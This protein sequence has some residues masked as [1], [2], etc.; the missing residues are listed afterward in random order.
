MEKKVKAFFYEYKYYRYPEGCNCAEDI[1]NLGEFKAARLK[2]ELCM[3]PDFV[4]ESIAEESVK[5]SDGSH[6]FDVEVNLYSCEEYDAL[7]AEQV[8]AHCYGCKNFGGDPSDLEGHHSEI[9]LDGS[10][11]LRQSK[12]GAWSYARCI[13]Y[14]WYRISLRLDAL[15][16]LIDGKRLGALNRLINSELTRVS[17]P[18]RFYGERAD[19]VYKLYISTGRFYTPVALNIIAYLVQAANREHGHL[20]EKGWV[21]CAQLPANAVKSKGF[22]DDSR[23]AYLYEVADNRYVVCIKHYAY[24]SPKK[25]ARLIDRV[26]AYLNAEL[27]EEAVYNVVED[28]DVVP[29]YAEEQALTMAQLKREIKGAFERQY[30]DVFGDSKPVFP[31]VQAY[32]VNEEA[33]SDVEI[34]S[35]LLPFKEYAVSGASSAA[36]VSLVTREQ[37]EAERKPIWTRLL[38][39]F[40]LY[41]PNAEDMEAVSWYLANT[42]LVP[43]PIRDPEND[44]PCAWNIG[45]SDCGDN[46]GIIEMLVADDRMAF[47]ILRRMSPVLKACRVRL[48]T[49]GSIINVYECDFKFDKIK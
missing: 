38:S 17:F 30:S 28:Y 13:D 2:E 5:I 4:Y 47:G 32:G 19:G 9:S 8:K 24:K 43:E 18:L 22:K 20:K 21:V 15:A 37:L 31:A 16:K 23:A 49:V 44:L 39:Y 46:G 3:A 7:L 14:F 1:I 11:Y 10:C 42:N 33:K 45:F 36:D 29:E 48:V 12:G 27:G 35:Q 6:I 26:N 40:Y 34:R 41:V 25:R